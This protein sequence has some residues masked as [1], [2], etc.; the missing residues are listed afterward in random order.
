MLL[1]GD[2]MTRNDKL[3]LKRV[4]FLFVPYGSYS[5]LKSIEIV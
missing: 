3:C 5:L 2:L 1:N 4:V